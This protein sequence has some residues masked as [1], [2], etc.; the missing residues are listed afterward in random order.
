MYT[1]N[2]L[3]VDILQNNFYQYCLERDNWVLL[4]GD[5]LEITDN[6]KDRISRSEIARLYNNTYNAE[7][8]HDT[9]REEGKRIGLIYKQFY[10]NKND[11]GVF[12]TVRIIPLATFGEVM[13]TL[14]TND[15][16]HAN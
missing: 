1:N 16:V 12:V 2:A 5:R 10:R 9:A 8:S 15:Q 3:H 4:I 14:A 13:H 6:E 11:R 7:V